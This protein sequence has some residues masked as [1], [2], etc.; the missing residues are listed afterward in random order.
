MLTAQDTETLRRRFKPQEHEFLQEF[1]YI[2]ESAIANRIE[3]VDPSWTFEILASYTRDNQAVVNAR[4]T[5]KGVSR[6]GVGM[7]VIMEKGKSEPEKGAATDALKRAARLFGIGRYLL[8]TPSNV[9]NM[10]DLTKW[11][12]SNSFNTPSNSSAASSPAMSEPQS[13]SNSVPDAITV[14]Q[15]QSVTVRQ[16]TKGQR[17]LLYNCLE[18]QAGGWGRDELRKAG[19]DCE[20]WTA[21]N[22]TYQLSPPAKVMVKQ[23]GNYWNIV[24]II[25]DAANP[26]A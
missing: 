3:E 21:V 22:A 9:R 10:T 15:A 11:L 20:Q 2:T 13:G 17:Y 12:G 8:D 26:A 14:W 7:Q 1:V 5:I 18:G 4:L 16:D 23:S 25:T 24:E 19:Y 6:D